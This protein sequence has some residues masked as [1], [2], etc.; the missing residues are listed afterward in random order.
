MALARADLE[1]LLRSR[2]L[3]RTLTTALPPL[4]PQDE[5][6]VAPSGVTALDARLG[7]GF[8]RGQ[9]SELVGPRSSGRTS[10]VLQ[11]IAAAT[12]RG[13]LVALVDVLDMLD[14]ESAASAGIALPQLLWVRGSIFNLKSHSPYAFH[15][16]R[17]PA[18]INDLRAWRIE[19]HCYSE[20]AF[21]RRGQPVPLLVLP[22][23]LRLNVQ[24]ERPVVVVLESIPVANSE[25]IDRIGD[26]KA[27]L[28]IQG[29]RPEGAGSSGRLNRTDSCYQGARPQ[30]SSGPLRRAV[31]NT[32]T[33]RTRSTQSHG[34][35]DQHFVFVFFVS[36]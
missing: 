3:D 14:V 13:E 26:L 27:V 17:R 20:R 33:P 31:F 28:V 36:S 12:S 2:Q 25:A 15:R 18:A 8:P 9:L 30:A 7:G 23:I 16:R 24:V 6:A 10:V 34:T 32:K 1:S 22:R 29:Q 11:M 21:R 19:S 5:S 4:D 35:P